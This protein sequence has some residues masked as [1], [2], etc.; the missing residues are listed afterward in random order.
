[1]SGLLD[2]IKGAIGDSMVEQ[3]SQ[4]VGGQKDGVQRVIA[5]GLPMMLTAL[6]KNARSESGAGALANALERD[7]DGGLLSQ[8]G[9]LFGSSQ[10][11]NMGEKILGHV[12]GDKQGRVNQGL[13][14]A[15]GLGGQD[16]SKILASLAPVVMGAL[17]QKKKQQGLGVNGLQELLNGE[18]SQMKQQQPQLGALENM[19]DA[20]GDGDVDLSD[21]LS[22]GSG[23]LKGFF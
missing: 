10:Q 16:V 20:D 7:H 15:S 1:M 5:A 2:T 9:G 13:S 14:Q 11:Q 3:L 23:L 6:Q 17:G 18:R 22:K 21:V 19:L 8:L 4:Q 12:L